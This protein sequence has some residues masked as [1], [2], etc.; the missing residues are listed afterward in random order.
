MENSKNRAEAER[1]LG[2]AEKLLMARDLVGGMKFAIQAQDLDPLL[3]GAD[4]ILA[5]SDVL[6]AAEKRI[7]NQMD[8][9]AILQLH[10]SSNNL[11]I[12]NR[13]YRRL[14]LL[15]HPSKNKLVGA[16]NAFKLVVD[17]WNVLSDPL[18]RALY[19]K[20]FYLSS[21]M[22]PT[23]EEKQKQTRNKTLDLNF[24]TTCPYCCNLYEYVRDYENCNLRC[25]NCKR[26]FHSA[27]IP[28]PSL[29]PFVP[30]MDKYVCTWGFFPLGIPGQ[31]PNL[32][33]G[34]GTVPFVPNL[35][36]DQNMGFSPWRETW[37]ANTS[38]TSTNQW[39]SSMGFTDQNVEKQKSSL[40]EKAK[41]EIKKKL[42]MNRKMGVGPQ[43]KSK[44]TNKPTMKPTGRE[45]KTKTHG[46]ISTTHE[47]ENLLLNREIRENI[48]MQSV[49]EDRAICVEMDI[50]SRGR[51][52]S[53]DIGSFVGLQ[54]CQV[55]FKG[56]GQV[57]ESVVPLDSQYHEEPE[58]SDILDSLPMIYDIKDEDIELI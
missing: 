47:S 46:I 49:V 21:S 53:R 56:I 43:K 50:G 14:A 25:Q 1:S 9:Y 33:F 42:S 44:V 38:K 17:A 22:K 16:D 27:E 8:W 30:G 20:Q 55:P 2:I 58:F 54:D 18:K 41:K 7:N 51:N 23:K 28:I 10:P 34:F 3:D 6:I 15:L 40:V 35:G 37:N 36:A 48:E 32:G 13:Q 12:M 11:E 39:N 31:N 29:P 52:A 5:I 45:M 19:D 4:R 24:W 57:E 26:V